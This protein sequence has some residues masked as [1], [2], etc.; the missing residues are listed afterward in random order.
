MD[1]AAYLPDTLLVHGPLG[2]RLW[3]WLLLPGITIV[4]AVVGL[5]LGRLTREL[6]TRIVKRTK[7]SWDDRLIALLKGPLV[8]FWSILVGRLLLHGFDLPAGTIGWFEKVLRTGTLLVLFWV[9]FQL[10]GIF[11]RSAETAIWATSRP[12]LRS[13]VPLGVRIGRVAIFTVGLVAVLAHLGYPVGSLLAGLGIGGL[14][15][16]LAGQKTVENLFGAFSIGLDEPFS[17]GDTIT[18]DGTSGTVEAIG[19]RSTRIRSADRTIVTL[20]N[21]RLAEMKVECFAPR[22]RIRFS[23]TLALVYD[24]TSAQLR[25]VMTEIEGALRSQPKAHQPDVVVRLKAFAP[26]YLDVEVAATF[27]T[28]D[29]NEFGVIRQELL[30]RIMEIVEESGSAIA[31]PT[32]TVHLVGGEPIPP[33]PPPRPARGS[34]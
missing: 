13:L 1:I 16:A 23:T 15:V 4:A 25:R 19:L 27:A 21:G 12:S 10:I 29:F 8:W 31:F 5:L 2:L 7:A 30:L 3:Q 6:L 28:T 18:V 14:A 26:E 33:P 11:G 20:P 24:T 34:S 32:R 22:D 9:G 17:V